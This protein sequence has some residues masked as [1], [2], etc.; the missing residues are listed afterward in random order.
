MSARANAHLRGDGSHNALVLGIHA[1]GSM[2]G[3]R[4]SR[5]HPNCQPVGLEGA[6]RTYDVFKGSADRPSCLLCP[7]APPEDRRAAAGAAAAAA[8][9]AEPPVH[10]FMRQNHVGREGPPRGAV[11]AAAD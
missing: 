3:R 4:D 6:A 10:A 2:R 5:M 8:A 9:A 7:V 1:V 11:S